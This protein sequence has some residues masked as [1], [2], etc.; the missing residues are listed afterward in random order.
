MKLTKSEIESCKRVV[1]LSEEACRVG[2][3]FGMTP[4]TTRLF[5]KLFQIAC[6][7]SDC[8]EHESASAKKGGAE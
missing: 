4:K 3:C 2:T 5:K 8:S 6:E 7:H 1:A